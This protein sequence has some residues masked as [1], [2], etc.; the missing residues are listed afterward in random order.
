MFKKVILRNGKKLKYLKRWMH[1]G[2]TLTKCIKLN[3]SIYLVH[4]MNKCK[5][6]VKVQHVLLFTSHSCS[7]TTTHQGHTSDPPT[8]TV[9]HL[10]ASSAELSAFC[11]TWS[12]LWQPLL[13]YATVMCPVSLPT[14]TAANSAW[15]VERQPWP[16]H[17]RSWASCQILCWIEQHP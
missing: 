1:N 16:H 6:Y 13:P 2:N 9:F 4:T 14:H 12:P 10:L 8:R 17:V 15:P 7:V 5:H 3:I 11:W